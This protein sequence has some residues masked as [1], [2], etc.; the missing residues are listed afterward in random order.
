M[1]PIKKSG[2][3][4][5]SLG[6]LLLM[7]CKTLK[8][9]LINLKDFFEKVMQKIR[10]ISIIKIA[11]RSPKIFCSVP[12]QLIPY[13]SFFQSFS[14]QSQRK[15]LHIKIYLMCCQTNLIPACCDAFSERN[16]LT[17]SSHKG[18]LDGDSGTAQR[19]L[20]SSG[21]LYRPGNEWCCVWLEHFREL[22]FTHVGVDAVS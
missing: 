6:S 3:K 2:W 11:I 1:F 9:R 7:V 20:S 13:E 22:I 21:L 14:V 15:K 19:L 12:R 4:I 17:G 18:N 5:N 8:K 16:Y 10:V